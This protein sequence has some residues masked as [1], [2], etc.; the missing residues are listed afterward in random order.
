[1]RK[2]RLAREGR[3]TRDGRFIEVGALELPSDPVP[4]MMRN[5]E[6]DLDLVGLVHG[7]LDRDD[8]GW[9]LA[10]I[11]IVPPSAFGLA[12]EVDLIHTSTRGDLG[13]HFEAGRICAVVLGSYPCWEGMEITE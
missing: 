8:D 6:G 7:P 3:P 1:M 5:K 4:L 2:I 13:L 12:A 10:R 11:G 9:V